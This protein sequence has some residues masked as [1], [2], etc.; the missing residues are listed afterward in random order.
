MERDARLG[1]V[2]DSALT[3]LVFHNGEET[4]HECTPD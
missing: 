2:N 1:P 3:T 4:A